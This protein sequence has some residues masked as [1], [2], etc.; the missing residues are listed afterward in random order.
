MVDHELVSRALYRRL[1]DLV[2]EADRQK[3]RRP[4]ALLV[5][6][7]S[8][9][10][11]FDAILN[12]RR[13]R[14]FEYNRMV[15]GQLPFTLLLRSVDGEELGDVVAIGD[16][17]PEYATLKL[18]VVARVDAKP[19]ASHQA[20]VHTE[21]EER[22]GSGPGYDVAVEKAIKRAHRSLFNFLINQI[23]LAN[24]FAKMTDAH[25]DQAQVSRNLDKAYAAYRSAL[26]LQG[27]LNFSDEE[28]EELGRR[29]EPLKMRLV[30]LG[31]IDDLPHGTTAIAC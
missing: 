15:S 2:L 6:D 11:I 12:W 29:I 21:S 17:T 19:S 25:Y 22:E 14:N 4:F 9:R 27:R 20:E 1:A 23:A 10:I 5:N 24:T 3:L 28:R 31:R 13:A 18:G 7:A 16:V 30:Q 26:D 8:G